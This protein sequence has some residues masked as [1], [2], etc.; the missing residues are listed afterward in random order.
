MFHN[1][2]SKS[3]A[4]L[5]VAVVAWIGVV[6]I[7]GFFASDETVREQV[8]PGQGKRDI[9][10]AVA[11]GIE[12]LAGQPYAYTVTPT[13]RQECDITPIRTGTMFEQQLDVITETGDS[14]LVVDRLHSHLSD[15]YELTNS[16][17]DGARGTTQDFI[18]LT[19]SREET[20]RWHA[21]TGCRGSEQYQPPL[22]DIDFTEATET[23]EPLAKPIG[24]I[25]ALRQ[26]SNRCPESTTEDFTRTYWAEISSVDSDEAFDIFWEHTP[27]DDTVL[28]D[29]DGTAALQ[30]NS[31]DFLI[32][33][34][35]QYF[36]D[37]SEGIT[38]AYTT[39]CGPAS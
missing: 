26:A 1:V 22:Y 4:I 30:T 19:L 25:S 33:W 11:S 18:D 28:V 15:K 14:D 9:Q 3:R 39:P 38:L 13:M 20:V 16:P 27:D 37:K 29:I 17:G 24:D 35:G 8:D 21:D 2:S 12:A 10:D 7:S 6:A 31:G 5:I 34:E 32:A 23:M 36:E